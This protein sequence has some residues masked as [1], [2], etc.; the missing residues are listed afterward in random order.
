MRKIFW[1]TMG[2]IKGIAVSAQIVITV[3]AAIAGAVGGIYFVWDKI[4]EPLKEKL[5][6]KESENEGETEEVKIK[7]TVDGLDEEA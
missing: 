6:A 3:L 5:R 4:V 7:E 1:K 2:F